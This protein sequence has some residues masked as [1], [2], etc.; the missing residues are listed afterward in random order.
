M[1]AVQLALPGPVRIMTVLF[2]SS[3]WS[4]RTALAENQPEQTPIHVILKTPPDCVLSAPRTLSSSKR[5]WISFHDG[6]KNRC[7]RT[8]P[9]RPCLSSRAFLH[10]SLPTQPVVMRGVITERRHDS[11]ATKAA[12]DGLSRLP[13]PTKVHFMS[14]SLRSHQARMRCSSPA[15]KRTTC[16]CPRPQLATR[17]LPGDAGPDSSRSRHSHPTL[18][19]PLPALLFP[20]LPFPAAPTHRVFY[21]HVSFPSVSSPL[22]RG[23]GVAHFVLYCAP[24]SVPPQHA[25]V[26]RK[27]CL[28][29]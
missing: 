6:K 4:Y 7:T 25:H 26:K 13:S 15:R 27:L 23:W 20:P 24:K 16:R 11:A 12:C 22:E 9:P 29:R 21:L 3:A 28:L 19:T 14:V 18:P 17:H 2:G 8:S 1:R 10:P 5:K